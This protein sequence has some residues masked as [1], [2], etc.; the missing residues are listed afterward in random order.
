MKPGIE[1]TNGRK[2]ITIP[3][4][5]SVDTFDKVIEALWVFK[6][7]SNEKIIQKACA[8]GCA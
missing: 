3:L 2:N 4:A 8:R 5:D 1:Y 7:D 6:S